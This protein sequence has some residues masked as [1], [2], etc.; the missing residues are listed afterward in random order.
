MVKTILSLVLFIGF[1]GLLFGYVQ[2]TYNEA[3]AIKQNAE[4]YNQALNKAQEI[5]ELKR[6]LLS[7]YNLF[8]DGNLT[9]LKKLLPEHIDNVR[10]V[11]DLDGIAAAH[12]I[13]I[14]DV[15]VQDDAT[16]ANETTATGA[17]GFNSAARAAQQYDTRV[18]EF[19]TV[20]S[21]EQ[22]KS[23]VED[24]ERSLR[25]V[26][27]VSLK[28]SNA[29]LVKQDTTATKGTQDSEEQISPTQEYIYRFDV[30]IRT[31]WLK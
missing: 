17:V 2:P 18:L 15:R 10:L 20:A 3:E 5:Q 21:Y 27:I 26:D 22:F 14:T 13:R 23:F 8:A 7:Q 1:F 28:I 25:I 12:N 30:G 11:F 29:Q 31:F 6:S 24:L 9:K 4:Q 16:T 19:T